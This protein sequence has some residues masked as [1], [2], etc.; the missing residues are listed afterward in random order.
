MLP[1]PPEGFAWVQAPAGPALVARALEP[2]AGHLFTTRAWALGS[3]VPATDADWQQLAGAVGVD[4]AHLVRVRQVHGASVVVCREGDG[5]GAAGP[6]GAKDADIIVSND[7]SLALAIQTADCVPLLIVDTRTRAVAAAHAGWRGLAARV[8]SV[9]IDA[10]AREFGSRPDDLISAIGPSVTAES[11]AVGVDV[12]HAF[13]SAGFSARHIDR[14]VLPGRRS[15]HL[16]FDGWQS[17]RDQLESAGVR[18]GTI[19]IAPPL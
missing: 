19:S 1:Q 2:L 4:L 11:Y 10:L 8:P 7:P 5:R 9:V 16:Q 6:A 3:A 12:R 13:Q 14:W 18:P 17:T 15:Q